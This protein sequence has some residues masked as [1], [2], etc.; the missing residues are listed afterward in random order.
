MIA[1]LFLALIHEIIKTGLYDR[2]FLVQ[3]TNSAELVNMDENSTEHG[4]FV[5]FEVP[6]EE[7]CF[8]A[9]NKLWWDRKTNAPVD[10]RCEGCDP[11]LLGSYELEGRP[12]KTAFQMLKERVE[13]YTP[14]WAAGI[15]GIPVADTSRDF[16]EVLARDDVDAVIVNVADPG[17]GKTELFLVHPGPLKVGL[18]GQFLTTQ[19]QVNRSVITPVGCS[20]CS[21]QEFP[22]QIT[23]QVFQFGVNAYFS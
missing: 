21:D 6:K 17:H 7:G 10:V 9:Q 16:R 2:E 8:D 14:E 5:R 12:V 23:V 1:A 18:D 11:Y 15:T 3:Y 4:M 20:G 13:E 19:P 22:F